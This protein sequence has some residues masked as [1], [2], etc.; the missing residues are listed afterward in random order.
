M[1]SQGGISI[2]QKLIELSGEGCFFSHDLLVKHGLNCE[3]AL[4][5]LYYDD[6]LDLVTYDEALSVSSCPDITKKRLPLIYKS[7]PDFIKK[8][9]RG[10]FAPHEILDHPAAYSL[11]LKYRN[12]YKPITEA[13]KSL[14]ICRRTLN[15]YIQKENM[16]RKMTYFI[17]LSDYEIIK[18]FIEQSVPVL[19]AA[20]ELGI[21]RGT[22]H[23]KCQLMNIRTKY[24]RIA[25]NDLDR[26]RA[27]YPA[28]PDGHL[29]DKVS[30]KV[31]KQKNRDTLSHGVSPE[32]SRQSRSCLTDL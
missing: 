26:Y 8:S 4:K 22:F 18:K 13:V 5:I 19:E 16:T 27:L 30:Q 6:C 29:C 32:L 1:D 2:A 9:L 15:R 7:R 23:R 28:S 25:H 17:T 20:K 10:K 3:E 21:H 31:Q 24:H 14:K 12:D 11:L